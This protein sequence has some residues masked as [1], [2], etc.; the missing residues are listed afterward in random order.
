MAIN[1]IRHPTSVFPNRTLS[2][3][4]LPVPAAVAEY[5]PRDRVIFLSRH[6]RQAL[7]LSA[8][9]SGVRLDDINKDDN[10]VPQPS[11]GNFWSISHKTL[12]VCGVVAPSPIGIDVERIRGFSSGLYKKT[13]ADREWALADME[14]D[15]VTAFFRYWTAKEAV[16]KAT[17]IGIKDLLKCRVDHIFDDHH[18][19]IQYDGQKWLIEHFYFDDHVASIVKSSFQIEWKLARLSE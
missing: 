15:S 16:L 7:R 19:Q 13:A 8:E 9:K 17:G 12:Y 5:Q 14:T 10:G 18:L 6:A 2:P 3:V 11:E 1:S 4:I